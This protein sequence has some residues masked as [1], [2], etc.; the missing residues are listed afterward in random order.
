MRATGVVITM[1][2]LKCTGV[3]AVIWISTLMAW[4]DAV[5]PATGQPVT[6]PNPFSGTAPP[7]QINPAA[8]A[9]LAAK[10]S[11]CINQSSALG[12]V[13]AVKSV[14]PGKSSKANGG[15][16]LGSACTSSDGKF[17]AD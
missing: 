12:M 16:G 5:T 17:S 1:K 7:P 8:A 10:Y 13:D 2:I 4:A 15:A 14:I 9:Q 11:S 6:L 3:A